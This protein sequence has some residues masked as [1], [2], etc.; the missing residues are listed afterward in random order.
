MKET[1]KRGYDIIVMKIQTIP[2][3]TATNATK[4]PEHVA[5]Y[6]LVEV[7]EP[8]KQFEGQDLL[9]VHPTHQKVM[10]LAKKEFESCCCIFLYYLQYELQGQRPQK[11]L[12][13]INW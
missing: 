1:K 11:K 7:G 6:K 13:A 12:T 2:G 9:G 3:S 8:Q 5:T 10:D 4:D